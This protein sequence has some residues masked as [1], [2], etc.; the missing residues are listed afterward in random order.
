MKRTIIALLGATLLLC[1]G[2]T[3]SE[4]SQINIPIS[5]SDMSDMGDIREEPK[6]PSDLFYS[7]LEFDPERG[8]IY[9]D[10]YGGMYADG[11]DTVFLVAAEDFSE[12]QYL[13]DAFPNEVKFKQVRYSWNYLQGLIDEYMADYEKDNE[14]VYTTYVDVLSNCAVIAVDEETLSHKTNDENSPLVFRLGK[15]IRPL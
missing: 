10:T 4:A 15:I 6:F 7:T 3:S 1:T 5:P 12:Y 13:L 14:K 8:E 11:D 2:C 9:P